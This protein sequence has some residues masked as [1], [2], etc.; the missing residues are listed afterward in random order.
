MANC[1]SLSFQKKKMHDFVDSRLLRVDFKMK[2]YTFLLYF[3][4]LLKGREKAAQAREKMMPIKKFHYWWE[5]SFFVE[6]DDNFFLNTR[7]WSWQKV[8]KQNGQYILFL[9]TLW[10]IYALY[11]V[12]NSMHIAVHTNSTETISQTIS[13]PN[14]LLFKQTIYYSSVDYS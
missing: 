3:A 12:I 5:D 2:K 9:F 13:L 6:K 7:S 11:R 4:E 10:N 8:I 14:G 1:S